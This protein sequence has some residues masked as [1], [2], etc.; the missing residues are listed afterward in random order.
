MKV[1]KITPHGFG[2]NS[3]ILTEDDERAVIIDCASE[4]V[5]DECIKAN[6]KPQ[7]V[8]LT[9]G[10]FDHVLGCG[11]FFKNGV[12]I[13]CGEAE[14]E[15]I[16]S[17]QYAE[18]CEGISIPSF[19]I[20]KTLKDGEEVSFGGVQL[21][22]IST[23]GHSAGGV[24]YLAKDSL[25]SGDTLFYECIGR[26]DLYTGNFKQ[27]RESLKKLLALNGDY[28]VYCGHG[29]DTTLTHERQFNPYIK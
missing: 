27:L 11:K 3:Y 8:L 16:F 20:Y 10:H 12:P 2:C 22:V 15:L 26:F 14:K 6:L 5:Y 13:Y 25:F 17:A 1:I 21:K 7:A 29:R 28:T 24:C 18:L 9:H 23:S 4:N 19:E